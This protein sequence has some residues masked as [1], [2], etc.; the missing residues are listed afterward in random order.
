MTCA[1]RRVRASSG[2]ICLPNW[3]VIGRRRDYCHIEGGWSDAPVNRETASRRTVPTTGGPCNG[4]QRVR[5]GAT[6]PAQQ[7]RSI[8]DIA[9]LPPAGVG[10][11]S[12]IHSLPALRRRSGWREAIEPSADTRNPLHVM[13]GGRGSAG[14]CSGATREALFMA[15][16]KTSG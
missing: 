16:K 6:P 3:A 8:T 2:V 10:D 7:S 13:S 5:P 9:D 1:D 11:D 4:F 14:S 15:S 12:F